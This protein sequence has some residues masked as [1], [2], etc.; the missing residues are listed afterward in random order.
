MF[1]SANVFTAAML[2]L[3][4]A[5]FV[6]LALLALRGSKREK[7]AAF[8][9]GTS[10]LPE[11]IKDI[12]A[13]NRAVARMWVLYGGCFFAGA[14]VTLFSIEAGIIITLVFSLPGIFV[15]VR[16]YRRIYDKYG[17]VSH[18]ERHGKRPFG[19]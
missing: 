11:E 12:P 18:D 4:G 1:A 6:L 13:Y 10:V 7:P 16:A 3:A 9:S 19:R 14:A 5:F 15:L 17:V 2:A 8:W